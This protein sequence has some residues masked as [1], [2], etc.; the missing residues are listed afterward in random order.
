MWEF[1]HRT[2]L[3]P[4]YVRRTPDGRLARSQLALDLDRSEKVALSYALGQAMTAIF[5]SHYLSV[6]FLMHI[7][8]YTARFSVRFSA[9]RR[10]DLFGQSVSG[11]WVVAEAKGRS[12]S[13]ESALVNLLQAQKQSVISVGGVP[14]SLALGSVA[15]FPPKTRVLRVDAFDPEPREPE[16]VA[17][18][19][20]IDRFVLAYYEPFLAA[21]ELG[22][23][24]R[25]RENQVGDEANLEVAR[26]D[27]VRI[28]IG[29]VRDVAVLVRRARQDEMSG[30]AHSVVRVLERRTSPSVFPDGTLVETD[31]ETELETQDRDTDDFEGR[32]F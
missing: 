13:M 29:L 19:V 32:S 8:R 15:S 22:Q 12:N 26:L 20:D 14:P 17:I 27:P 30:L 23:A 21:V 16:L 1:I 10:A 25:G 24:D 5:C 7:D 9:R 2:S 28:R 4:A 18:G 3:I 31:W 6:R 11:G